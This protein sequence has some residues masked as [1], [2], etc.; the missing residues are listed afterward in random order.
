MSIPELHN[1]EK[2]REF[3][4]RDDNF[5]NDL[6]QDSIEK[7]VPIIGPHVG[8]LLYLLVKISGARRILELGTANGYSTIWIAKA[9]ATDDHA[10]I[11]E[12]ER[13]AGDGSEDEAV[14]ADG[15]GDHSILTVEWDQDMA[16]IARGNIERAGYSS[17]VQVIRGDARDRVVS[18]EEGAFDLIFLDVEKEFYSE[19]LD[20]S[21]RLLRS[22]GIL[23]FDNTAFTTTGD[24]LDRS[25]HHP[26][27]ETLHMYGF[28]PNHGPDYD[29]LTLC[30]K[31]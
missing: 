18:M 24:F 6:E 2:F 22:G 16:E 14:G 30:V 21:I 25:F 4:P 29:A 31:K 23:F 10:G 12:K 17:L 8:M 1:P 5:L 13:M 27:L 19:L 28:L 3:I 15:G 20:P 26:Q 9:M 11:W 7:D